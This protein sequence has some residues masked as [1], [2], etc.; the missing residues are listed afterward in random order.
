MYIDLPK[1]P[2]MLVVGKSITQEQAKEIIFRTDAFFTD[3][4]GWAGNDRSFNDWYLEISGI[5]KED[6]DFQEYV[7]EKIKYINL[8]YIGNNYGCSSFIFGPN[9]WCNPSGNIY[10]AHNIGKWPDVSEVYNEWVL[11]AEAFPFLDLEATLFNGESHE[12]HTSPVCTFYIKDGKVELGAPS[13]II[14]DEYARI[15]PK[16]IP[17]GGEKG[18]SKSWYIDYAAVINPL[19]DEYNSESNI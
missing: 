14:K 17:M 4:W 10:H 12:D 1:W 11:V 9:G 8:P 6:W 5:I 7:R 16:V 19:V 3:C 2:Q 18:L 13:V 15:N